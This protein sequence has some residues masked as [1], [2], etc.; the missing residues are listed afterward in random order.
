M[1][2]LFEKENCTGTLNFIFYAKYSVTYVTLIIKSLHKWMSLFFSFSVLYYQ[3]RFDVI[4]L[5]WNQASPVQY[6]ISQA[7]VISTPPPT[8]ALCMAAITGLEHCQKNS[9]CLRF[10]HSINFCRFG[11]CLSPKNLQPLW[12]M[13]CKA[14]I[15]NE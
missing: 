11:R 7:E 2:Y 12:K 8:Q 6:R 3:Y 5:I 1:Y 9:I 4:T 13:E 10:L 15:L 14:F